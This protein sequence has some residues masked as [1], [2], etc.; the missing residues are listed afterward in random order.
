MTQA[1]SFYIWPILS[2]PASSWKRVRVRVRVLIWPCFFVEK[3]GV[4]PGRAREA[5]GQRRREGG[6][7]EEEE[8]AEAAETSLPGKACL[9]RQAHEQECIGRVGKNRVPLGGGEQRRAPLRFAAWRLLP[10]A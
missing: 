1:S 6:G 7:G 2:G 5:R 8:V 4:I 9:G 3:L 10:T